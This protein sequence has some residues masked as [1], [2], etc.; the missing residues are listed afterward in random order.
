[1]PTVPLAPPTRSTVITAPPADAGT[2]TAAASNATVPAE[3]VRVNVAEDGVP[4]LAPWGLL[5]ARSTVHCPAGL[6]APSSGTV[7]VAAVWPGLKVI[8]PDVGVYS[9]PGTAVPPPV[10]YATEVL[11]NGELRI[12]VMTADPP[13]SSAVYAG[14]PNLT[15]IGRL[16]TMVSTAV[17]GDPRV[18]PP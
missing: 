6:A 1:M 7:K 9:T 11:P 18:A 3:A 15:I 14:A 17:L 8:M 4:R 13:D 5:S 12:T 2:T 10:A 16:S